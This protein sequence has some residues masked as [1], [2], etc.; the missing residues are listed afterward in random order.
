MKGK[1]TLKFGTYKMKWE[2]ESKPGQIT[3]NFDIKKES[4]ISNTNIM[5]FKK[6]DEQK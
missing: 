3:T 6:S 1:K 2:I 4:T 5:E